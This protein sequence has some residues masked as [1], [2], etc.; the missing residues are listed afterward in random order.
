MA[1]GTPLTPEEFRQ[2]NRDLMEKILDRAAE[3]PS[4]KQ[5]LL[6]EPGAAIRE[7][8]FPEARQIREIRARMEAQEAEVSGQTLGGQPVDEQSCLF[9][10]CLRPFAHLSV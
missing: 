8:D 4:W 1:E 6:K 9:T 2:L 10:N 5:R 3:D 7:A